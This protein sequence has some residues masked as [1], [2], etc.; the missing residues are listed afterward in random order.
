MPVYVFTCDKGHQF[1]RF[2]KLAN[3]N[4]PQTCE[5]GLLAKRK[6]VPTM[7]NCDIAPWDAYVSPATGNLITSYQERKADMKASGCV[8]YEP[9]MKKVQNQQA[10]DEDRKLDKAVDE[11]VERAFE[12]MPSKKKESLEQELKH[13]TLEYTRGSANP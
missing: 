10:K 13:S 9:S 3:Y 11:T 4:D 1:D 8:D 12:A 6:I 7:L 2:L 5:C